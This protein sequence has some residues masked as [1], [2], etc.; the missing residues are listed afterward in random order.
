MA[1][2]VDVNIGADTRDFERSVKAGMQAPVE[3]AQKALD[4]YVDAAGTG[5]EDLTR[6][7][8]GQQRATTE[9]KQDID[10]LNRT[11]RDGSGPA[12]RKAGAEVD[13]FKHKASEG[14]DEVKESARSNA[15]EVG[16]SFTGGMDQA[17]GGL[18]GFVAEFLAGF[19]P[20]GVIAGV[21]AAALLGTVSQAMT[22][23]QEAADAQKAAVADLANEYLDAGRTGRRTFD[24]VTGAIKA[25]A[26]STDGKDVILTLQDAFNKAQAAGAD[27]QAVVQAI[28]SGSPAEISRAKAAVDRLTE[29]H[30]TADRAQ[31]HYGDN[32]AGVASAST[33]ASESIGKALDKAGKQARDA[34]RAEQLAAK[35]GISDLQLKN[36]LLNQLQGGYDDAAGS[37]D[38]YLNKEKTTLKVAPY[39]AA[40]EAKRDA[41]IRYKDALAKADLSPSAKKFLE[42]QGADAAAAMMSGYATASP[43]QKK[44][45]NEIWSTS[46]DTSADSYKSAVGKNLRAW[47]PKPPLIPPPVV[48]APDTSAL[49]RFYAVQQPAIRV[50]VELVTRTG[51]RI[52]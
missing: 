1:N 29:A 40:M 52:G 38:D 9:L 22:D 20:A 7:F 2:G 32:A 43:A 51:Q 5:G 28:A 39:I 36:D 46:G 30:K 6:T 11:I 33:A 42:S 31:T 19:G 16:A 10:Q 12:Y 50:P 34:A 17:V 15:I 23:G 47:E 45:L 44:Q 27:Y 41:L 24:N 8:T 21:G 4:D 26:T 13:T 37:V 14:F 49:E 18:Q 3:D 35:A 25:M 48:P